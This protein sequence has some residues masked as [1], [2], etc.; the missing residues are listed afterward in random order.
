MEEWMEA[1]S[2][3]Y[4]ESCEGSIR[5]Q[6][7]R[8]ESQ[9]AHVQLQPAEQLESPLPKDLE[10]SRPEPHSSSFAL[11]VLCNHESG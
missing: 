7:T 9:P 8:F 2:F 4:N 10:V 1:L 3:G 5:E 6:T 11:R